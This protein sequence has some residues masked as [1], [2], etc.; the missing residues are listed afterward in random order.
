M[1]GVQ[2]QDVPN[3]MITQQIHTI[4]VLILVRLFIFFDLK[5]ENSKY[6]F[7]STKFL[8]VVQRHGG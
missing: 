5:E 2:I 7:I 3:I 1:F 6:F 8:S 4:S